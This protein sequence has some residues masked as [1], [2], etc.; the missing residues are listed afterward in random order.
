MGSLNLIS[1]A[2]IFI[3]IGV[4]ILLSGSIRGQNWRLIIAGTV[5][6]LAIGFF[7]F[8]F[9]AG[10][11]FFSFINTAVNRLADVASTGAAFLF[12]SLALPPGS[13]GSLGF[14]LAFQALPTILFFSA[15]ISLLYHWGVMQVLIGFFAKV[16][17]RLFRTSGAESMVAASSIFVGIEAMLTVR[18]HLL[19]MTRSEL[20]TVIVAGLATVSSNVMALY[21]FTLRE[22]LPSIGGHLVT[23]SILSAPA[24]LVFSKIFVPEKDKPETLGTDVAIEYQK[25]GS[26]IEAIIK[27]SNDGLKIIAGIAALLISVLGLVALVDALLGWI[28]GSF[29]DDPISLKIIFSYLFYPFIA[30]TGVASQDIFTIA[31]I[32]GERLVITEV[33]SY[34]HLAEALTQGVIS[35]RSAVIATYALCGFTHFASLAIFAGGISAIVPERTKDIASVSLKALVAATFATLMTACIAGGFYVGQSLLL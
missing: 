12:G 22:T 20:H 35:Q 11:T 6:Q 32:V 17:T 9:E 13:E 8:Q 29:L 3:L 19:K 25:E 14:F 27:A 2:G 24:A 15:L 31:G 5:I 4:A 26:F 33:V 21:I 34:Q 10:L 30:V 1:F 7:I 28:T 23:A 18:P 16:F